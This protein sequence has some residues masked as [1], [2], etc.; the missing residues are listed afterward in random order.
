[1]IPKFK[2]GDEVVRI[3]G[4]E[5]FGMREGDTGVVAEVGPTSSYGFSTRLEGF[6]GLYSEF[7]FKLKD[8]EGTTE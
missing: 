4:G 6:G 2:V 7:R 5:W 1:M 3:S 8:E